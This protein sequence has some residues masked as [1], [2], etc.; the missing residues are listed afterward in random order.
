MKQRTKNEHYIPQ[1][2]IERF[3]ANY[4]KKEHHIQKGMVSCYRFDADNWFTINSEGICSELY[5][6]ETAY[7]SKY[8]KD[9][10]EQQGRQAEAAFNYFEN[11]FCTIEGPSASLF[12]DLLSKLK[13]SAVGDIILS[14]RKI[15]KL[16]KYMV[17]Q[18]LRLP[19]TLP[20]I[21]VSFLEVKCDQDNKIYKINDDIIYML[22]H[23][24]LTCLTEDHSSLINTMT[25]QICANYKITVARASNNRSFFT[26]NFPVLFIPHDNNIQPLNLFED[27]DILFVISPQYCLLFSNKKKHNTNFGHKQLMQ[28]TSSFYDLYEQAFLSYGLPNADLI[29]SDKL[30]SHFIAQIRSIYKELHNNP[31]P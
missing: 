1:S 20:L 9:I 13:I 22:I 29:F 30:D 21:A 7:Y 24:S 5:L 25:N 23:E 4:T 19:Q 10:L 17:L 3:Y 28:A 15:R 26:S 31:R 27:C 12:N 16:T 8:V 14:N 11:K 2:F 18:L 6:Y